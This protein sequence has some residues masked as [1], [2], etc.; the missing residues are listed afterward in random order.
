[1]IPLFF[2][3]F[4]CR[5][6]WHHCCMSQFQP[7]FSCWTNVSHLTLK[8]FCMPSS[9]QLIQWLQD[10]MPQSKPKSSRLHHHQPDWT[11]PSQGKNNSCSFYKWFLTFKVHSGLALHI[12]HFLTLCGLGLNLRSS[13]RTQPLIPQS[14]LITTSEFFL[15]G[16]RFFE[17]FFP[18]RSDWLFMPA[19]WFISVLWLFSFYFFFCYFIFALKFFIA[20]FPSYLMLF[21]VDLFL[22]GSFAV[23]FLFCNRKKTFFFF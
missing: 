19:L 5:F 23:F 4:W 13:A 3:Q 12:E 16:C 2:I 22:N 9:L 20:A 15:S 14:W 10:L 6:A 11:K 7:S 8:H 21:Y 17:T 18:T 1:M